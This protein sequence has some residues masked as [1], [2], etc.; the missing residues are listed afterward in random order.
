[1]RSLQL[2][3]IRRP[4]FFPNCK[5]ENLSSKTNLQYKLFSKSFKGLTSNQN[6][7][8]F[9]DYSSLQQFSIKKNLNRN[10]ITTSRIKLKSTFL[11]FY[12]IKFDF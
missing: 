3:N 5:N 6:R 1:M 7:N 4:Y 12:T 10:N 9:I 11:F 2:Q 8:I